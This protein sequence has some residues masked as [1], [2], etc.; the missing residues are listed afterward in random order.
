ALLA[1]AHIRPAP[2][3]RLD[4]ALRSPPRSH[5]HGLKHQRAAQR[6]GGTAIATV[7]GPADPAA[8]AS[9]PPLGDRPVVILATT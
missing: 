2:L 4:P 7:A 1:P 3:E 5:P 8:P 6:L 9:P